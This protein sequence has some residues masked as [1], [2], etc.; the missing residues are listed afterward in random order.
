MQS[1]PPPLQE[2]YERHYHN[3]SQPKYDEL[4]IVFLA[5]AQQFG[6]IFFV[7]DALDECPLDARKHLCNFFL[8]IAS[9]TTGQGVVK[10][11]IMSRKEPDIDLA[12]QQKSIPMIEI[13]AAKVDSDIEVYVKA[14]IELRLQDHRLYLR[15]MA[16]KDK[17]L[18]TLTAK[19]DGMYVFP[20]LHCLK[21]NELALT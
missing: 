15:N 19:A 16:L 21:E 12:F 13:Q 3:D 18:F 2:V 10:L 6:V 17:I 9:T 11:F 8:S 5:T 14:Q 20:E 7:V 4:R 1:L